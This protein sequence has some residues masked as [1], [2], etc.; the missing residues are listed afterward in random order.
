MANNA[1]TI[2]ASLVIVLSLTLSSAAFPAGEE[3]V[4]DK[5][6]A[7]AQPDDRSYLPPSM[8][9]KGGGENANTPG[10]NGAA[11]PQPSVAADDDAA[12]KARVAS[13]TQRPRRHGWP[14]EGLIGGFVGM[15][16]R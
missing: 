11:A 1:Q 12:K 10:S 13:Q 5:P 4:P 15:F 7:Q 2:G 9:G 16:G 3:A 6:A 8:Q 14:G